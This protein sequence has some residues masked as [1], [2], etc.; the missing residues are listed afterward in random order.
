MRRH[1]RSAANSQNVLLES[2]SVSESTQTHLKPS[3]THTQTHNLFFGRFTAKNQIKNSQ[4]KENGEEENA[5]ANENE[6]EERKLP[7]AEVPVCRQ[8]PADA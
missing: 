8:R 5:N 1:V 6:K 3:P 2:P 4:Q 7:R